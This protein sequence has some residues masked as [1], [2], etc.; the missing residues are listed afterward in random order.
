VSGYPIVL[1]GGAI[2]A[3]V[4]GGGRVAERKVRAL[5]AA[6][7]RV[8]LVAP[9]ISAALR[10]LARSTPRCTLIERAYESGD[11]A[12]A[13]LAFAAT[14]QRDVNAR[15]AGDAHSEGVLVNIADDGARG[16]FVTPALHKSGDLLIAVSAGGVPPAAARIRDAIAERF[17]ERYA[18]AL[19]QLAG[20]RSAMLESGNREGWRRAV[21]AL[22]SDGFCESVESGKIIEEMAGWRC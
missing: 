17:D 13:T 16:D 15:I 5:L 9:G 1:D 20:L 3:V 18:N 12:G 6:G 4:V 14:D 7:A 22:L 11:L 21:D 8:R 2:A 19:E 10:E